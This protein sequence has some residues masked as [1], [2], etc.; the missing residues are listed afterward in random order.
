V[1]DLQQ[2]MVVVK[3]QAGQGAWPPLGSRL[4]DSLGEALL[5]L[6]VKGVDG[7]GRRWSKMW[8]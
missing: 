8:Q 3:A 5:A 6:E 2:Q 7:K 1:E 4:R